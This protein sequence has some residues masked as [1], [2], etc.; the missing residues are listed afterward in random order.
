MSAVLLVTEDADLSVWLERVLSREGHT[1]DAV[2]SCVEGAHQVQRMLYELI[3]VDQT[4]SDT[5][6]GGLCRR[7][8]ESGVDA[9]VL[10]LADRASETD[11]V[12]AF[13]AGADAYVTKPFRVSEFLARVRALLRRSNA[14]SVGVHAALTMDIRTRLVS[15]N[16]NEVA[17]CWQ[18]FDLLAVLIREEGKVVSREALETE[19]W[20]AVSKSTKTLDMHISSLRHFLGEGARNSRYID[21]VDGGGYLFHNP[22]S[23]H[24]LMGVA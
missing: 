23:H 2:A 20:G 1:V 15:I 11:S 21:V 5:E 19:V 14:R 10:I 6:V 18:Q 16:D 12:V 7:M 4:V 9:R 3:M 22:V 24:Q 8:R 13:D 17:L